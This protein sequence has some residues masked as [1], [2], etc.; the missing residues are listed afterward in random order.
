[1]KSTSFASQ[2]GLQGLVVGVPKETTPEEF[3][4]AIT[5]ANVTKLKKAGALVQIETSAGVGSG[6]TDDMYK[7][8]GN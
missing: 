7:A 4:V 6:F 3:R 1:M 8:A 5:P 2:R